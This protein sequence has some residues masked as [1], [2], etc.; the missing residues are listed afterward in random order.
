MME[1]TRAQGGGDEVG[2]CAA[3][4]FV[5]VGGGDGHVRGG[6]NGL[7]C[8]WGESLDFHCYSFDV[9]LL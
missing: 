7:D 3:E 5:D 2:G 9:V 4:G 8:F 6:E 1:D